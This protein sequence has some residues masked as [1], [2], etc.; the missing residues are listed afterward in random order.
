MSVVLPAPV[1]PEIRMFSRRRTAS[2]RSAAIAAVSVP[3]HE[4]VQAVPVRVEL[5]DRERRAVDGNKGALRPHATRP[6]AVR[7][8]S[9][10]LR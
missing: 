6:E 7:P 8:E 2:K 1:R 10:S 3:I 5:P 4:L 9:V